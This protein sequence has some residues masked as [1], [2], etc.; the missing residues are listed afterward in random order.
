LT[1]S[2]ADTPAGTLTAAATAHG[3]PSEPGAHAGTWAEL[4]P[5]EGDV[6]AAARGALAV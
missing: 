4:V 6:D 1:A 3:I 5:F 2:V